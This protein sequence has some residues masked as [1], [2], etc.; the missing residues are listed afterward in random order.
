MV[1]EALATSVRLEKY[2][3]SL[4]D[5]H[6]TVLEVSVHFGFVSRPSSS[7]RLFHAKKPPHQSNNNHLIHMR[8]CT[9]PFRPVSCV[10]LSL[11]PAVFPFVF[12]PTR[13]RTPMSSPLNL[14]L[15]FSRPTRSR[16]PQPHP[17]VSVVYALVLS[18]RGSRRHFDSLMWFCCGC[19]M[20]A[21][22]SPLQLRVRHL[23]WPMLGSR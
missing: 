6:V 2:P 18:L 10:L 9:P 5:L 4:I 21:R 3:K 12:T 8:T 22:C 15:C 1:V 23:R 14:V 16:Q 17:I 13:A 20:M 11:S 19:R 7:S